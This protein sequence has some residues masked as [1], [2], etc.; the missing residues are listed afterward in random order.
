MVFCKCRNR[1]FFFRKLKL[2][3]IPATMGTL[4][5]NTPI[6]RYN[7]LRLTEN[8]A[9]LGSDPSAARPSEQEAVTSTALLFVGS[10]ML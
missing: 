9:T 7:R 4:W 1:E 2:Y 6:Y 10:L 8:R 5:D 3:Q